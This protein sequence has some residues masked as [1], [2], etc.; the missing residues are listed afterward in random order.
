MI[1]SVRVRHVPAWI[2]P[3]RLLGQGQWSSGVLEARLDTRATADLA[4]RLR[5]LAIAGTP[6]EL[7]VDPPLPR[8]AVRAARTEDARRRRDTTPGFTRPGARVDEEGRYSLTPE[9]LALAFGRRFA[10]RSVVDACCGCGGNAIGFARAGCD[11]LALDR[12]P[13]RLAMAR[14]N[15]ALYGVH[16]RFELVDAAQ[17]LGTLAGDVLFIDP[18]WADLSVLD[19][20]LPHA[21]RF[22]ETW[23]KLPPAYD[24]ALLGPDVSPEAV[25]G[26][27]PG[28]ARRIKFLLVRLAADRGRIP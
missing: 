20:L 23:L 6:V 5:G 12:D 18:P 16:V 13:G 14:H 28:D 10:G 1:H 25:Y 15:A 9:A 8:P 19:A 11:V 17:R 21:P 7:D 4:A 27:A 22:G 24:P 26:T 3:E 2:D